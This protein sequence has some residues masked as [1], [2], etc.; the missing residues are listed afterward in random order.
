[1]TTLPF[2]LKLTEN[3]KR[4]LIALCLLLIL[5]IVLVGYLSMVVKRIMDR[6]GRKIDTM[7]YDIMKARVIVDGKTF[8]RV[9]RYKS[10]VYFLK[11]TWLPLLIGVVFLAALLI[12]G[13][14]TG[15]VGLVFF[16]DALENLSF[17][18]VWPM[19]D[20]F[21]LHIPVNWPHMTHVPDMSFEVGKYLSYICLIGFIYSGVRILLCVQALLARDLRI[22]KLKKTYFSK[23][24]N[25]LQE[26]Q[27]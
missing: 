15:D 16:K 3:D 24:L 25:K 27:M 2:L 12:Y 8:G 20:F 21:G 7:M 10:H 5:V 17:G 6:Q 1:M 22:A 19:G 11:K 4:V 18:L 9:A 14:A 13:A 26:N 23:D